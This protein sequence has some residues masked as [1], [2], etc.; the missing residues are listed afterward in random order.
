VYKTIFLDIGFVNHFNQ[1]DLTE[2]E[3]LVTANE[4]ILAEQFVGQELLAQNQP[5]LDPQLYYWSRE[6]KSSNAEID[7]IFQHKNHI[8]PVEV[9]AGKT[10]TLKSMQLYL[11]EK[12]FTFE[13]RAFNSIISPTILRH[14]SSNQRLVKKF[15]RLN[16]GL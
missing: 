4:G 11:Y 3:N 6:E 7:F 5:W 12:K 13:L 9:K 16:G 2:L 1:I 8:Y 10:G 14:Q 15:Y